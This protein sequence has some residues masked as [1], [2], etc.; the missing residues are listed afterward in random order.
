[1][2]P[3]AAAHMDTYIA[4]FRFELG[5]AALFCTAFAAGLFS[6]FFYWAMTSS[7]AFLI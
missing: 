4:S 3:A 6:C 1:M 7:M 5:A 2:S